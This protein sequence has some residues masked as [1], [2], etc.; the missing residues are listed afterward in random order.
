MMCECGDCL[1]FEL[2]TP[3]ESAQE[4]CDG[5][6]DNYVDFFS[7]YATEESEVEEGDICWNE[8]SYI[9]LNETGL[10]TCPNEYESFDW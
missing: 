10:D 6:C 9:R 5:L 2:C 7:F 3:F 1:F 4:N 8:M